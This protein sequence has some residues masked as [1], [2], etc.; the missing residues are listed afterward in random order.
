M[1]KRSQQLAPRIASVRGSQRAFAAI[2]LMLAAMGVASPAAAQAQ[3]TYVNSGFEQPVLLPGTCY[4]QLDE[5]LVPGWTTTHPV[6]APSGNCTS[7]I[8]GNGRL[9][10]LWATGFLGVPSRAGNNFAELNASAASRLYQNVC[11]INGES[12]NWRFSHRGRDSTTVPDVMDYN[13]G[14]SMPIVRVSTTS[15]GTVT[16]AP[17][18]SQGT[19]NAPANGGNGWR[20]YSGTFTY[21]GATGVTSMGFESISAAGGVTQGNFLDNIQIELRPFVDFARA[22]SSTPESSSSN[23]PTLRVNGQAFAAFTITVQITGGT[24]TLGTDYT[25]PGNSTTM[26]IN[27]PPG[28]YDGVSAGSLFA[29]PITVLQDALVEPSETILLQIQPP[30]APAPFLIQSSNTCGAAGQATYTY[31]IVD[32]DSAVSVTKNAGTPVPVAGNPAQVDVP[33]TIVVTNTATSVATNYALQDIAGL[34]PDTSVAAASFTRNG[35][36][37][38]ALPAAGPWTLQPQW[39]TLAIGASDTYVLTLRINIA[40]GGSTGNDQCGPTGAGLGLFN[41]AT[42]QAQAPTTPHPTFTASAC[43]DTPTPVWATLNKNVTSRFSATDQF[44]IRTASGGNVVASAQTSGTGT[45]ATTGVV[46]ITAGNVLQFNES[47]VAGGVPANYSSTIA[48]SNA[49][50]GS[51]TALP[52]GAGT[53]VAD[54]RQWPEVSTRSGDD[55]TCTITNGPPPIDLAIAKTNNATALIQGDSTTYLLTVSNLSTTRAVTGPVVRDAPQQGLT[56]PAANVVTCTGPSGACPGGGLT[57][58]TLT[59]AGGITLGTLAA[60]ASLTLQFTCTVQ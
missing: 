55:I 18:V 5:A 53:D 44:L 26:T 8:G 30:A 43:V 15:N 21:N 58:G 12:I 50:A 51:P 48:C 14:A 49:A 1:Q 34:D 47:L 10:E 7:P 42:V 56:C 6:G 3:R 13:I 57:V 24:A 22:S 28:T 33:Y 40:R 52:S 4:R 20:D 11:L 37:S 2:G 54:R 25:T 60:G 32:D 46:V 45:T 39:R 29:L 31:T 27:V 36:A 16:T 19:A 23:L 35:G 9:I 59:S 41:T 17:V 38:T